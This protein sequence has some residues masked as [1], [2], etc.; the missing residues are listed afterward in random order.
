MSEIGIIAISLI[1]A[2]LFSGAEAAFMSSNKLRFE[3]DRKRKNPTSYILNR[4]YQY[5]ALFLVSVSVAFIASMVVFVVYMHDLLMPWLSAYV[6]GTVWVLLLEIIL[7]TVV[8]FC[9][10]RSFPQFICRL[11]PYFFLSLLAFP[12]YLT[13]LILLPFSLLWMSLAW[14]VGKFT[15]T[16]GLPLFS[17]KNLG[18]VDLDTF[19]KKTIESAPENTPLETEVKI[20]Q[21]ALDFSNIR[22]KDCMVPRTEI[23]ALDIHAD[24]AELMSRFTE[25]G[26]S[27][28]LLYNDSV[29]N[30]VGYIHSSE[31]FKKPDNWRENLKPVPIVPETMAANKLM[32]ILMQEKKTIAIVVD[33]FGGTS[34]IVT[35]E[36][37]VEEIFGDFEDEHDTTSYVSKKIS[38]SEYV[39]SGRMEI[40]KVNEMFE[41]DLPESD[42]YQTVAGLI[43][44]IHQKF[45]Q[46]NETIVIKHFSFT[47]IKKT[48]AKIE[49]VKL[50]ILPG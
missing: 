36:D 42:E 9:F 21:N 31:M 33:E 23:V 2:A 14:F 24:E 6:S 45:P 27:K 35:L 50:K 18:K 28:I 16:T 44:H 34:G 17:E 8:F 4:F 22:L 1:C 41:L 46:S 3:L 32:K 19:I 13:C 43:L 7:I 12:L 29:D 37:L 25:T 26:L 49:L 40:D 20:F 11:H 15:G 30:I 5:S 39:L 47:V 48:P 38:D 10:G